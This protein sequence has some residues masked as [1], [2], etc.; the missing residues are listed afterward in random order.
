MGSFQSFYVVSKQLVAL[1]IQNS[2]EIL[3]IFVLST[4][5]PWAISIFKNGF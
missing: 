3:K 2:I 4:R 1:K 5:R